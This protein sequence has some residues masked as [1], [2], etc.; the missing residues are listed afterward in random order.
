MAKQCMN[1]VTGYRL[2]HCLLSILVSHGFLQITGQYLF[3]GCTYLELYQLPQ[4]VQMCF[5]KKAFFP[6]DRKYII[7]KAFP[8]KISVVPVRKIS[9]FLNEFGNF[10]II[11][12]TF[13]V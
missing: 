7:T 5:L 8:V 4:T 6:Q 10:Y 12:S 11:L 2:H 13:S 3:F 1:Q 9:V